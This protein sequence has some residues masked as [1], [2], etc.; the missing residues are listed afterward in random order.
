MYLTATKERSSKW[1]N[2]TS[3]LCMK[4]ER[5]YLE[6]YACFAQCVV[7]M[8]I[9]G[10][11]SVVIVDTQ[12]PIETPEASYCLH[13]YPVLPA[14]P[15]SLDPTCTGCRYNLTMR[16]E[17]RAYV[18]SVWASR[19]SPVINTQTDLGKDAGGTRAISQLKILAELMTQLNLDVTEEHK[20]RPCDA[21]DLIGG[22][23]S[24]G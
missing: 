15:T 6:T 20:L 24:G 5:K 8:L 10:P 19:H 14:V 1:S 2:Y 18:Y 9:V 13:E 4:T 12:T 16:A 3:I 23:G 22:A 17:E 11:A 7:L 21:F